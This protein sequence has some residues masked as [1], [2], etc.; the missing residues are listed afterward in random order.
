MSVNLS[1]IDIHKVIILHTMSLSHDIAHLQG[2]SYI[3]SEDYPLPLLHLQKETQK[4]PHSHTGEEA[5]CELAC[6]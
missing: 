3:I 6:K 4:H 2:S 1:V 5:D